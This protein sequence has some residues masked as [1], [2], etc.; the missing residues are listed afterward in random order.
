M[1]LHAWLPFLRW[2]RPSGALLRQELPA[3]LTVSLLLLPQGMAYAALAGMP[4]QSGL[5]A[6]LLPALVA[7]LWGASPRL[8]V[9]PTA[10]TSLLVGASLSGLAQPGS[11]Q[12]VALAAWLAIF[13]GVL[14]WALGAMRCGWLIN[15]VTAPVLSGFTQAAGLLI[16]LSQV[17]DLLGL[18]TSWRA[19]TYD[20]SWHHFN[21]WS[22]LFGIGSLLLLLVL[23]RFAPRWPWAVGVLVLCAA[24]SAGVRFSDNEAAVIGHLPSGLQ[25]WGLPAP[26]QWPILAQL[27]LPALMIALVSFLEVAASAQQEH[28]QAGT[29]WNENQD[30]I[31]Q[32]MAKVAAGLTGSFAVSGS[33]S[34]SAVLLQHGART[35]WANVLAIGFVVMAM[36]WLT[37][38]LYHVPRSALAAIVV[39]SVTSLLR[40]RHWLQLWRLSKAEASIACVTFLLTLL[41]APT[42]YWG[43]VAGILL[44]LCHFLYHRLHPRIVEIGEHPDGTLR[45]RSIWDLPRIAPD[46]LALRMDADW[47]FASA[48]ALE[49]YIASAL[50]KAPH[51]HAIYLDAQSI[52]RIDITGIESF[53]RLRQSLH[54]QG[55]YWHI[56][57]LKLPIQDTLTTAQALTASNKL[58]LHRTAA[59]ALQVLRSSKQ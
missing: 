22:A 55:I 42:L 38:W 32:G 49:R 28:Q 50:Q 41:T 39:L 43:V 51:T 35:G 45:S 57:G 48:R 47:D 59:Q 9:G 4:L 2:P 21:G 19:W 58:F 37:P 54:K 13:A 52:N 46:V 31:A 1:H 14:Q 25:G 24:I 40:P 17:P 7:V 12:W 20:P 29:R 16:V 15:V 34:R 30:L 36:L 10:I 44:S 26:V 23:R 56:S 6:A 33:F 53:L 11:A 18:R 3:A 27:L 8:G 5:Y